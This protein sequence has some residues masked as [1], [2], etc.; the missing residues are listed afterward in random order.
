M[1]ATLLLAMLQATAQVP[2]ELIALSRIKHQMSQNLA[3]LPNFICQAEI[4]RDERLRAGQP[5]T[6]RDTVRLEVAHAGERELYGWPGGGRMEDKDIR[7]LVGDG[8]VS[9]GDFSL[10]ATSI[11]D[12]A[13]PTYHFEGEEEVLARRARR[14]SYQ[15]SLLSS[16]YWVSVGTQEAK[17]AY[18]GSFWADVEN[19][20]VLRLTV[21]ADDL[22]SHL[23]MSSVLRTITYHKTPIGRS[24][25][26]LPSE[27]I[28]EVERRNGTASRNR[29]V[30]TACRQFT[31][32]TAL[33]FDVTEVEAAAAPPRLEGL[34]ASPAPPALRIPEGLELTVQFD[35]NVDPESASAGD[36]LTGRLTKDVRLEG[37][38]LFAKGTE[39]RAHLVSGRRLVRKEQ[40]PQPQLLGSLPSTAIRREEIREYELQVQLQEIAVG[41]QRVPVSARLTGIAGKS[42][43]RLMAAPAN[44]LL[45]P[46]KNFRF[47]GT[48]LVFTTLRRR[49]R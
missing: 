48:T 42:R 25:Y 20:D 2:P 22:P 36:P 38:L 35:T 47:A 10:F 13:A 11:F 4:H 41:A 7:Q 49:D 26:L 8:L 18:R 37:K 17:V 23:G 3:R 27:A 39:V 32:E 34:A 16:G 21:T 31:A 6:T 43:G 33:R 1:T 24:E 9:T 14:Y 29:T 45:M 30:F 15:V 12:S 40:H 28:I 46:A 5:F 19:N 44:T